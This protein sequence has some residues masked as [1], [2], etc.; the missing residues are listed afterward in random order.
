MRLS[1]F[2]QVQGILLHVAVGKIASFGLKRIS[3]P[4]FD[5]S[6]AHTYLASHTCTAMYLVLARVSF[7]IVDW[8]L[9]VKA[10]LE[11]LR[12][13]NTQY[14][15][16]LIVTQR[17][18]CPNGSTYHRTFNNF[19]ARVETS[20]PAIPDP[21]TER[22]RKQRIAPLPA[23]SST[24]SMA[25]GGGITKI[26]EEPSLRMSTLRQFTILT[27]SCSSTSQRQTGL[28]S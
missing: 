11:P 19:W 25:A 15:D 18:R 14:L 3:Y 8:F 22:P 27:P 1:G 10:E 24:T 17:P 9:T 12:M 16:S 23:E 28:R 21:Q 26:Q 20:A 13:F 6:F 2:V 4:T 5:Y 7:V